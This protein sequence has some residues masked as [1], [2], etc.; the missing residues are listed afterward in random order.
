[1]A[2][3]RN[4]GKREQASPRFRAKVQAQPHY[5]KD[6]VIEVTASRKA[7]LAIFPEHTLG[8][9]DKDPCNFWRCG[10]CAILNHSNYETTVHFTAGR[11]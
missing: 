1:M 2:K 5:S 4:P 7:L 10:R 11:V 3:K 8:C 9:S 6:Q